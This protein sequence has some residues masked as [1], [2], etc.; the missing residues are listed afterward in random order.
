[1]H[2]FLAF[3]AVV[4]VFPFSATAQEMPKHVQ[5]NLE[6]IVGTWQ[7][8]TEKD[9]DVS[10]AEVVIEWAVKG[11]ALRFNWQGTDLHTKESGLSTG[12]LGWDPVKKVVLEYEIGTQGYTSQGTHH[13]FRENSWTSPIRGTNADEQGNIVW[14]EHHRTIEIKSP[15]EWTVTGTGIMDGK[16]QSKMVSTF[17][18]KK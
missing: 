7:M 10:T 2:K 13:S 17:T 8:K 5:E 3:L 12:I 18:R 6:K 1:M 14:F 15:D 16:P 4:A 9:Q 11:V